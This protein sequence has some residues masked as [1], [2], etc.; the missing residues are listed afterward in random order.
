M[1]RQ[2]KIHSKK[3]G[4]LRPGLVITSLVLAFSIAVTGTAVYFKDI[5]N[6]YLAADRTR[7]SEEEMADTAQKSTDLSQEIQ[8]E[9]SVLLK[10]SKNTLPLSDTVRQVNVFGWASTQWLGGGSGS[11]RITQVKTDFLS[12]LKDAGISYNEE[13]IQMYREFQSKRPYS[14]TLNSW[15]EESCRLYEPHISDREYYTEELLDHARAYSDTAI[16]VVGRFAGESNDCP[17]V[18]YKQTKKG[19]EITE[20]TKRTYLDLS[21]EEEALLRYAGVS[22]KNVILVLNTGN[23]MALGAIDRLS[24]IDAC[25]YAGFTG[26]SG[27]RA[28]PEILWGRINP[29]GRTAD[30]WAYD[31][32]TAASY[33]NAGGEGVGRYTNGET[34]YP[35]DGTKCGNLGEG[36]AYDQVS[37]VD[38]TEGIYVGYRWYETADAQHFWDRVE[39][40]YGRGYEGVVQYPFGYGLSYTDFQWELLEAPEDGTAPDP[41][42]EIRITLRVT[43]RGTRAGKDVV[44]LYVSPPYTPGEIEKSSVSLAAYEKTSLLEPGAGEI[45]TLTVPVSFFASYDERD[46][47]KNGFQGYELEA[48][49]YELSLRTDAHHPA[50]MNR[51]TIRL[52]VNSGTLYDTDPMTGAPVFNKFTGAQAQ[53]GISIDGSDAG[54]HISYLSRTDFE[55]SFPKDNVPV[56][57]LSYR[58][59]SLNLYTRE[60][61][62]TWLPDGEIVIQ[63]QEYRNKKNVK[64]LNLMIE[65]LGNLTELG[66]ELGK[67]WED[68]RWE[69]VLDQLTFSDMENLFLHGYVKTEPLSV[70]GKPLAREADGP[71]QIGSFHQIPA[72]TGF[73]N[74][75]VLA[76][77]WNNELAREMGRAVAKEAGQFGYSGWYAPAVNLH[78]SPFDGRNYEYYSEDPLISGH[79]GGLVVRGSLDMG[80]YCYVKHLICNDQ[81]SGI[82]RDGIYT[83][84]TEQTLREL[85]LKPFQM[86]VQNYGA[87]GFMTAYNRIGA[88]WAGGSQALLTGILKDEWGFHGAIITDYADHHKYMNGDQALRAGGSLW[89]DGIL[90]DGRF[91]FLSDENEAS[92]HHALRRASKEVLYM[93]LNARAE[94][95]AYS[96]KMDDPGLLKPVIYPAFPLWGA[97]LGIFDLMAAAAFFVCLKRTKKTEKKKRKREQK[98]GIYTE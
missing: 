95:R 98:N 87:T 33:A 1:I 25:L 90:N 26:E 65:R 21:E 86:L 57:R 59:A 2:K 24:G 50:V 41:Y 46:A 5:V 18:Q 23:V 56:R 69:E 11:G 37:Y 47:N 64:K 62:D 28:L 43:N 32:S 85:Y 94:N 74:A 89:M 97:A 40:R 78:R 7:V 12:A 52:K 76:Q 36:F 22:Y 53:D 58:G 72:G 34:L 19:G 29:S 63:A 80:V 30:T 92:Y 70:L 71:A 84:M 38:Y 3:K 55:K 54:Q 13:L 68:P 9:G 31:F 61:A 49:E 48:G 44:Q 51:N 10:N 35:A 66:Y 45:L 81:E 96:R 82:Y 79:M 75:V 14:D 20:D 27:A 39:N 60:Q 42:G 73:P 4:T 8:S 16:V 6:M 77:S 67:N 83:W 91:R 15:P 93:Y 88:V 17:R